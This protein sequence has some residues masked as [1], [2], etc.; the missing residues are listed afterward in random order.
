MKREIHYTNRD[1]ALD[2]CHSYLGDKFETT[3]KILIGCIRI[4][5]GDTMEAALADEEF[6]E[7]MHYCMAFAGIQGFPARIMIE[8]ALAKKFA[9]LDSNPN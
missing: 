5:D 9:E 6:M 7:G 2:D 8:E 3:L 4:D 1:Q